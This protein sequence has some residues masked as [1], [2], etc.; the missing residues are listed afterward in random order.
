[1]PRKKKSDITTQRTWEERI[2]RAKQVKKNWRDLFKVQM[3]LEYLDGKQRPSNYNANEWITINNVYSHL[4][5][6]LPAL[7]SVDPYFYVK[8]ARSYVPQRQMIEMYEKKGKVR[9]SNLNYY[10]R[11]L[12]LKPKA[13][14]AIQDAMFAFGVLRAEHHSTVIENPDKG[15]PIY[16]DAEEGKEPE[17]MV[18]DAGTSL[19]E[20]DVIPVNS[21]YAVER[22][23]FDDFLFDED[24][25]PLSNSWSW[26]AERMR[27]PI[28]DV[29]KNPLFKKS[30]VKSLKGKAS[31]ES[32]EEEEAREARKKGDIQDNKGGSGFW[33]ADQDKVTPEI[34][35]LWKI[36]DLKAKKWLVIGEGA[37]EPLISESDL[38]KGVEDHPYS[39]LRFTLRD[40]S[41]YPIPPMSQG[42]DPAKEYN[43]ARS[44]ILKHRKRFNRKYQVYMS[45]LVSEDE[46]GKLETGDDGTCIQTN[47]P[48]AVITPIQDAQL[49]QMRWQEM[50]YLRNEMIELFGGS[51]GESRGIAEADSA[52][53]A[54]ILDNRLQMKEG[55]ALSEVV[56]WI[57]TI[58]KKLD[59]LIQAHIDTVQAVRV[60]GTDGVEYMETITPDDYSEIEGEY[61]Y[62]VNVGSTQPRLPQMERASLLAALQLFANAPQLMVSK[63]MVKRVLELHHIEDES[64]V[65]EIFNIGR[66]MMQQQAGPPQ[67]TGSL[68]NVGSANP[69][70]AMGGQQGGA[71]APQTPA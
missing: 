24:A 44:D 32:D 36:W 2:N 16:K 14:L 17:P 60:T 15:K 56:D 63:R 52:T 53:Q 37:E 71:S 54:G 12:E 46:V 28:E 41:P 68:P 66:M 62:E 26:L 9:A 25:G 10:K 1:M 45:G 13:R 38:P 33:E 64:M 39:I 29:E 70:S 42:L 40:D 20:P 21:R 57:Q 43:V 5:A 59:K 31:K 55:D 58:A 6:Q 65:E 61:I 27:V 19:L 47:Q 48:G 35:I 18:D 11:E 23:H 4:K 51:T 7:Y 34:A 30:A 3:A 22:V 67:Q 50:G 69:V 49:D 8:I